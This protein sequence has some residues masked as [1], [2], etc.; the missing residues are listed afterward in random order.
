MNTLMKCNNLCY[1][2]NDKTIIDNVS[3]DIK[4]G[5]FT[6]IIGPNSSGKSTLLKILAGIIPTNESIIIGYG[7]VNFKKINKDYLDIGY[8]NNNVNMFI[9][10]DVF[11]EFVF[12]LENLNVKKD[13]VQ[14][15][16]FEISDMFSIKD[17]LDK[18]CSDLTNEEK[19]L[20]GIAIAFLHKPKILI[21]D[22]PFKGLHISLRKKI[23]SILKKLQTIY[24]I[25][26]IIASSNLEDI[27]LCDYTYVLNNGSVVIEGE[28][29]SVLQEDM[30][31]KRLGLELPFTINLS[32][33]LKFY[34]LLD[35]TYID[36]DEVIDK[37][38]N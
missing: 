13:D 34:E 27:L 12:I 9:N 10:N 29:L 16:I 3:L 26:I 4:E 31:L 8:F 38:W 23:L 1:I 25:T 20:V 24:N 22:D 30:Y 11:H 37:L 6:S 7:Y 36:Y 28:N 2:I 15:R 17:L 18:K 21:L 35:K 19:R 32:M 5:S 33:M 14:K